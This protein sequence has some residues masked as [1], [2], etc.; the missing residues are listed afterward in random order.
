MRLLGLV[1]IAGAIVVAYLVG[2]DLERMRTEAKFPWDVCG[3]TK[4]WWTG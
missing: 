1:V 4:P 3:N 2:R